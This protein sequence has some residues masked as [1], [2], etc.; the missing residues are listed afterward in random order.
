MPSRFVSLAILIYWSIAAFC[1]LTWDVLPE[2]SLGYPPDLRAIAFAGDSDA[3]GAVEHPGH[4]RSQVARHAP[5]GGRGGHRSTRRPDG[6]YRADQPGRVRRRRACS[7]ER[8]SGPIANIQLQVDSLYRVDPSGNLHR[9]TFGSN[10]GIR[11][12]TLIKVTGQLNGTKME[13][14][15]AVR[16][17]Y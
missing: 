15:P 10:R 4:R 7:R 6:W 16:C 11:S 13:I 3:A 5:D 2:L 1:L 8:R 12:T 17:R 9:S 14:V